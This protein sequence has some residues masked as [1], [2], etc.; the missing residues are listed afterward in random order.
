MMKSRDGY[1]SLPTLKSP[2]TANNCPSRKL[3]LATRLLL[4]GTFQINAIFFIFIQSYKISYVIN[5]WLQTCI[6]DLWKID[7]LFEK[8]S[9]HIRDLENDHSRGKM[10]TS[11]WKIKSPPIPCSSETSVCQLKI[12]CK[13][14]RQTIACTFDECLSLFFY[15]SL[16]PYEILLQ[17]FHRTF[18][19]IANIMSLSID[20]REFL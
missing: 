1:L 8:F 4:Y 9:F 2:S 3:P 13:V 15:S 10:Y 20:D 7:L 12:I 18:V 19:C 17:L 5:N 14:N 11:T 16:Y 6:D